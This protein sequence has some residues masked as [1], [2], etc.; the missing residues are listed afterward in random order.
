MS[1]KQQAGT[2]LTK[3]A[4]IEVVKF[5]IEELCDIVLTQKVVGEEVW[6]F[7]AT[8]KQ[9]AIQAYQTRKAELKALVEA[10]P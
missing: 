3:M 10:L 6:E 1:L 2:I 7:T 4:E 8:Q 5:K 9:K